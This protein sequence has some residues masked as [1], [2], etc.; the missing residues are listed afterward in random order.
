MP[1]RVVP[2]PDGP[3][4]LDSYNR[5]R[6]GSPFLLFLPP[7]PFSFRKFLPFL[8]FRCGCLSSPLLS[9]LRVVAAA[10]ADRVEPLSPRCSPGSSAAAATSAPPPTSSSRFDLQILFFFPSS[11]RLAG[12]K[13]WIK[14]GT[15]PQ[16]RHGLFHAGLART[17][18]SVLSFSRAKGVRVSGLC[19]FSRG[20]VSLVSLYLLMGREFLPCCGVE[21]CESVETLDLQT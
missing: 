19:V 3:A 8:L 6:L 9:L 20:L 16:D 7:F 1:S 12:N 4:R 5:H 10:V 13:G 14:E 2:C 11:S 15:V 21:T 18:Q 17:H